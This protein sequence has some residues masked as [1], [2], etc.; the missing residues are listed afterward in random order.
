MRKLWVFG[1]S[2]CLPFN[3]EHKEH[4]WVDL[5]ARSLNIPYSNL[6]EPGSD[7][8][9]IYHTYRQALPDINYND[10]VI[11]GWSHP[12]RKSFVLDRDN[13]KHLAVCDQGLIYK[14]NTQEFFR[15]NN[16]TNK[17]VN[18]WLNF[19]PKDQG[20]AYYDIWFRDYYSDHEQRLNFQ[21]Y[22]DSVELTCP[23]RYIPFYFSEESVKGIDLREPHA[24]FMTEFIIKHQIT[25]SSIDTHINEQGHALWAEHLHKY[26]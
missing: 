24:G 10:L 18:N 23:G 8:L 11:I 25:L 20:L 12:S 17:D 6:S 3:L 2:F 21:S 13:P 26:I 14:T 22:S 5:L 15:S 19:K 1:H 16:P 7:N 4:C 9:F